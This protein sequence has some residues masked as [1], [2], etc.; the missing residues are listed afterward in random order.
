MQTQ[1]KQNNNGGNKRQPRNQD[2]S[3]DNKRRQPPNP[4]KKLSH[5]LSWALRHAAP[6]LGL[7]MT[8]DG[9]VPLIEIIQCTH[10]KLKGSKEEDVREVV[11]NNDKQRF[12]LQEKPASEYAASALVNTDSGMIWCI[13]ANQGHSIR[14]IDPH[15]LLTALSREELAALPVIVHGT[16]FAAWETIAKSGYLSVMNRQHMHFASG[17][18]GEDGVISGMRK[19][20]Q[21]YIYVNAI[22]CAS[23]DIVFFRSDNGVL[24]TSG[25]E[26]KLP[27]RYF[28][29]VTDMNGKLLLDQ[30]QDN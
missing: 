25:L 17:L 19:T 12:S 2:Q 9:Y 16:F 26:G 1:P 5:A 18:L 27:K 13:R 7:T 30:R 15:A 22:Q 24:L 4:H 10:R 29:H 6:E 23:D 3:S 11:E 20:C 14:G 8:S 21:V 28:S